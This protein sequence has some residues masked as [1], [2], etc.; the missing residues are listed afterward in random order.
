MVD[1]ERLN[2]IISGSGITKRH[3]AKQ[4]HIAEASLNNKLNG[5]TPFKLKDVE[6]I[7]T[8]FNIG[9]KDLVHIFFATNVGETP[10]EGRT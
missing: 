10:T 3:L 8:T 9:C 5:N 7:R 4:M 6:V 1:L 2:R